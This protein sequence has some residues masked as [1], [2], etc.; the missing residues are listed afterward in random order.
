[1]GRF[2][3]ESSTV[4]PRSRPAWSSVVYC[5]LSSVI[6]RNRQ[7]LGVGF[8][9]GSVVNTGEAGVIP[10]LGRSPGEGNGNPLWYSCLGNP[11]A[12]GA[13]QATAHGV[14]ES[15]TTERLSNNVS[16]SKCWSSSSEKSSFMFK[17]VCLLN[18]FC[19]CLI[20]FVHQCS[21]WVFFVCPQDL[22]LI[23]KGGFSE[24]KGPLPLLWL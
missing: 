3:L 23:S 22:G 21:F 9:A 7:C 4:Q 6:L 20:A 5:C 16:Q 18:C 14:A 15:D 11:M 1:M 17:Q 2:C 13:W 12:R 19:F 8:H 10:G 24:L